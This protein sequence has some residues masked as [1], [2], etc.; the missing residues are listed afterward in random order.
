MQFRGKEPARFGARSDEQKGW[1]C[2]TVSAPGSV[3]S[4]LKHMSEVAM[5]TLLKAEE[6]RKEQGVRGDLLN[7]MS[8]DWSGWNL[9]AQRL[10]PA[11][12]RYDLQDAENCNIC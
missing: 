12:S 11:T 10:I 8:Q 3:I 2:P 6:S 5:S 7:P 1:N 4:R 9:L